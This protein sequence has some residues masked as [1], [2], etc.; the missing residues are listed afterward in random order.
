MI[1]SFA[2]YKT[3]ARAVFTMVTAAEDAYLAPPCV[4]INKVIFFLI[5]DQMVMA[6]V[7]RTMWRTMCH[8]VW[9]T[10]RPTICCTM[11]R[12]M[13]RTMCRTMRRTMLLCQRGSEALGSLHKC[14]KEICIPT[15]LP[16]TTSQTSA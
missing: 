8:T 14:H 15:S 2:L 12:K 10:M 4:H 5:V 6:H 7:C 13:W 11:C 16:A 9:C 3:S 1:C